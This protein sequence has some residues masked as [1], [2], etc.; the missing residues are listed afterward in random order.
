MANAFSQL[1][2]WGKVLR[3]TLVRLPPRR[4]HFFWCCCGGVTA[5]AQSLARDREKVRDLVQ[6]VA[7]KAHADKAGINWPPSAPPYNTS[8]VCQPAGL[9]MVH[10]FKVRQFRY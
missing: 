8:V 9:K 2:I 4:G 5:S 3:Q 6:D 7:C 10:A 1:L